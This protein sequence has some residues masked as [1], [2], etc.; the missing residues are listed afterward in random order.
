MTIDKIKLQGTVKEAKQ[1]AL[2]RELS[3]FAYQRSRKKKINESAINVEYELHKG[4]TLELF[5]SFNGGMLIA[6]FNPNHWVD[7]ASRGLL[8][9]IL[10]RLQSYLEQPLTTVAPWAIKRIDIAIDVFSRLSDWDIGVNTKAT[11]ERW[12]KAVPIDVDGTPY[13][14]VRTRMNAKNEIQDQTY[15][16][17]RRSNKV[18]LI[19]V[20]D[21]QAK[22]LDSELNDEEL[23]SLMKGHKD[24]WRIEFEVHKQ[25]SINAILDGT[26]DLLGGL[27]F[28]ESYS[29]DRIATWVT[30]RKVKARQR[31]YEYEVAGR[32]FNRVVAEYRAVL[33]AYLQGDELFNDEPPAFQKEIRDLAKYLANESDHTNSVRDVWLAN[34]NSIAKQATAYQSR[35]PRAVELLHKAKVNKES[36]NYDL[37]VKATSLFAKYDYALQLE[38]KNIASIPAFKTRYA[39]AVKIEKEAKRKGDLAAESDSD[40]ESMF[41]EQDVLRQQ[42]NE[43]N[44]QHN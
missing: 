31:K 5:Y 9:Y 14:K 37:A 32:A 7:Q 8:Y 34:R 40:I 10:S 36:P 13:L 42:Y 6:E 2:L 20:Y 1:A 21:K 23:A 27:S 43:K 16:F 19:R 26:A 24:Y 28:T 17:G 29:Y 41:A 15:Y 35:T 44:N 18:D 4:A 22:A 30:P 38:N 33:Y 11:S 25:D 3:S 12:S 39:E